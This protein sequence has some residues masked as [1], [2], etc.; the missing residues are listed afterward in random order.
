[1]ST[2]IV[3]ALNRD[4]KEYAALAVKDLTNNHADIAGLPLAQ[5]S[6]FAA[7]GFGQAPQKPLRER[8]LGLAELVEPRNRVAR[9][10]PVGVAPAGHHDAH[11]RLVAERR[12]RC[13]GQRPGG[14]RR[15]HLID[16]LAIDRDAAMGIE[17]EG[18]FT[19]GG[20]GCQL[21]SINVLVY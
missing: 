6:W 16:Q 12:R 21:H 10:G 5:V 7:A 18:K 4:E 2:A 15:L 8:L 9:L 13:L 20:L 14:H 19:D 3:S 11:R 1:M 17:P